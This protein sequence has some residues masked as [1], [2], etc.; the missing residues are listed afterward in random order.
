MDTRPDQTSAIS[1]RI[2]A[3]GSNKIKMTNRARI[4]KIMADKTTD[5]HPSAPPRQPTPAA[6]ATLPPVCN[7]NPSIHQIP[8][9][10]QDDKPEYVSDA[11][12]NERLDSISLEL[13]AN[14]PAVYSSALTESPSKQRT[15]GKGDLRK[16]AVK[17]RKW[18]R[19]IF[20]RK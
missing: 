1:P 20:R 16:M 10:K 17:G 6:G 11:S 15:T 18:M 8:K 5:D 3:Y 2:N 19:E 4:D 7:L 13:M 12:E 14:A 9:T